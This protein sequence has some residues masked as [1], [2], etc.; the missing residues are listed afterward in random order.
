MLD[1]EATV[2]HGAAQTTLPLTPIAVPSSLTSVAKWIT[3]WRYDIDWDDADYVARWRD[4]QTPTLLF[5][6]TGDKTVP[7]APAQ[8]FAG[9]RP[10][11]ITFVSPPDV[12]H[13]LA[14]NADPGGYEAAVNSFLD[15]LGL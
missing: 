13:V 6:G 14:W 3:S 5:Q 12:G 7:F 11:M 9:L 1:L 15:G 2:D 10:D 4:Y 8:Q